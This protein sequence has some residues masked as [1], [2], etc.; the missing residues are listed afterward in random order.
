MGPRRI[1]IRQQKIS[2]DARAVSRAGRSEHLREMI[3]QGL[4]SNAVLSSVTPRDSNRRRRCVDD[5]FIGAT[6]EHATP[7]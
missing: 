2:V 6:N 5:E 1:A 4:Y 3:S 7:G